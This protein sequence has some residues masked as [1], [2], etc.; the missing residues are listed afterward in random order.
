M[1]LLEL[2][3]VHLCTYTYK[4]GRCKNFY[5]VHN[6]LKKH[7]H[8][9]QPHE[10]L[11]RPL[12]EEYTDNIN[13]YY[14]YL[15][16]IFQQEKYFNWYAVFPSQKTHPPTYMMRSSFGGIFFLR[17]HFVT[18]FVLLLNT[19]DDQCCASLPLTKIE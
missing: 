12:P 1:G 17:I 2:I 15:Y 9:C 4:L 10:S 18:S 14:Y 7:L 16:F 19:V 13:G 11:T 8:T 3:Y 6:L 5:K